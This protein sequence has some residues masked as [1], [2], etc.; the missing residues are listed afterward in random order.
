M[1]VTAIEGMNYQKEKVVNYVLRSA[2]IYQI[3]RYGTSYMNKPVE[4]TI[5]HRQRRSRIFDTTVKIYVCRWTKIYFN[6]RKNISTN[7]KD[8]DRIVINNAFYM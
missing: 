6:R 5:N 8:I 3:S 7:Q 1:Y 4:I 2:E